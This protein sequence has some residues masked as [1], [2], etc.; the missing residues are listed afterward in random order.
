[1]PCGVTWYLRLFQSPSIS[2]SSAG[3]FFSPP[4][5]PEH[6]EHGC[7]APLG[8]SIY[9]FFSFSGGVPASS[10]SISP[11]CLLFFNLLWPPT[12]SQSA[13]HSPQKP[14]LKFRCDRPCGTPFFPFFFAPSTVVCAH[15]FSRLTLGGKVLV[16]PFSSGFAS[17]VVD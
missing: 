17:A 13:G 8:L 15:V 16:A 5:F 2:I 4:I 7:A 6:A 14:A 12:V 1:L 9:F 11:N 10:F 3:L